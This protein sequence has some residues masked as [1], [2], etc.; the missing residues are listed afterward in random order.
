MLASALKVP[1]YIRT[2]N[3]LRV[4]KVEALCIMLR[5]LAYPSRLKDIAPIFGRAT[6]DISHVSMVMLDW[7]H[8]NHMWR[9]KPF[10]L[11]WIDFRGF[12]KKIQDADKISF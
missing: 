4:G 1:E 10:D 5:R 12:A 6:E 9:L 3:R 8:L 11:P 2:R 7:V